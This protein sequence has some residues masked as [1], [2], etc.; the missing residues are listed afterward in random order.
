MEVLADV[1]A[2]GLKD[3]DLMLEVTRRRSLSEREAGNV[4]CVETKFVT[5]GNQKSIRRMTTIRP[6]R[7]KIKCTKCGKTFCN[8]PNL[9]KHK[10]EHHPTIIP[11][12]VRNA[13]KYSRMNTDSRITSTSTKNDENNDAIN[14]KN[15]ENLH[16]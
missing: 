7:E 8:K 3:R 13:I 15:E 5:I 2:K 6:S 12:I 1:E 11:R 4:L 10:S 16:A 9:T 14:A